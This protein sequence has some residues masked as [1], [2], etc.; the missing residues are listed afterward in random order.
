MPAVFKQVDTELLSQI[1]NLGGG[2]MD[3][4]VNRMGHQKVSFVSLKQAI[5]SHYITIN[6]TLIHLLTAQANLGTQGSR[7]VYKDQCSTEKQNQKQNTQNTAGL[8]FQLAISGGLCRHHL[9]EETSMNL[10]GKSCL[11]G[12]RHL[13]QRASLRACFG[14]TRL[15][16]NCW[17]VGEGLEDYFH[18]A[19][20]LSLKALT[21]MKSK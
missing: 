3:T 14:G 19:N 16:V 18:L 7:T 20:S 9:D 5:N 8:H 15:E 4:V 13:G 11:T 17:V 2:Q 1:F 6:F 21:L 12:R 10:L